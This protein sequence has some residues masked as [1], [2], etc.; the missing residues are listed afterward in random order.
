MTERKMVRPRFNDVQRISIYIYKAQLRKIS[1]IS[2]RRQKSKRRFYFEA[3]Q[4]Y[5]AL[6]KGEKI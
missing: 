3:V 5:I 6:F 4:H 1:E 2:K